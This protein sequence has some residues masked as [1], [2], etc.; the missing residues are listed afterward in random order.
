MFLLVLALIFFVN[1]SYGQTKTDISI[2]VDPRVE[3]VSTVCH[4]AGYN[5]YNMSMFTGYTKKVNLYFD[6]YKNHEAVEVAK[7]LRESHSIGFNAPIGLATY[8]ENVDSFDTKIPFDP[9]PE[10]LDSRWDTKAASEFIN[11]LKNF[12]NDTDLR[13]FFKQNQDLYDTA[14]ER[15]SILVEKHDLTR[16]FDDYFGVPSGNKFYIILGLQN[17]GA[18]Y[19]SRATTKDGE[20]EIYSTIGCWMQDE[21]GL[22][23]FPDNIISTVAHEF[24]HSYTNPIV[25]KYKNELERPS[26]KIFAPIRERMSKMAYPSWEIM[27]YE[28]FVRATVT[29]FMKDNFGQESFEKQMQNELGRGFYWVDD[30]AVLF[31]KYENNRSQYPH[32]DLFVPEIVDFLNKNLDRLIEEIKEGEKGIDWEAMKLKGPQILETAP[33]NGNQEVDPE[34]NEIR[35]KF[36]RQMGGGYSV[37]KVYFENYPDITGEPRWEEEST[38]FILPVKLKPDWD[39]HLE[40]NSTKAY[41]FQD[42][43]GKPLYPYVLKFRTGK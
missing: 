42:K 24:C 26:K 13:T 3:L 41:S 21:K 23:V 22:P 17:G 11:A 28:S 4:L 40:F 43:S 7:R 33:P 1:S 38:L 30:L 2:S 5:E 25:D 15:F 37:M 32:F 12:W 19:A 9:I 16:W 6:R 31:D 27:M 34:L 29:R 36:D 8:L 18:N 14:V 35:I 39:Y 10:D 20:K